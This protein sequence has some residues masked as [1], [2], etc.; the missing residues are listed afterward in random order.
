MRIAAGSNNFTLGTRTT[1]TDLLSVTPTG[2]VGIGTISPSAKLDI[3][4]TI[5]IAD[6]TQGLGKILTSDT[7][8]LASWLSLGGSSL[9]GFTPGQLAFGSASGGLTQAGNLYWNNTNGRLGVGTSTPSTALDVK[10]TSFQQLRLSNNYGNQQQLWMGSVADTIG[11]YI[12]NNAY[13]SDSYQFMPNSTAASG[14]NFRQ[15][16]STEFW[17]DT[18]LS[19]GTLYIPTKRMVI[20]NNGNVGI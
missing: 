6:G 15:D 14:L 20:A 10:S 11:S 19:S 13:Y 7:N 4:G 5:R 17:G 2:N 18:G 8:G 3:A 12:G 16:G 1:S 9:T